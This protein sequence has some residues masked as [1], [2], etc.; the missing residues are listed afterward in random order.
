MALKKQTIRGL[1][2]ITLN[3]KQTT[4]E[5]LITLSEGWSEKEE[6]LVRKILKQGGKCKVGDDSISVI[7]PVGE[8]YSLARR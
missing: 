1:E 6:G 5:E 8:D 2:N 4:K 7:R 3:G